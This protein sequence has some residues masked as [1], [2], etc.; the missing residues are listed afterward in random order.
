MT[1]GP[2]P[3]R[4]IGRAKKIAVMLGEVR[5]DRELGRSRYSFMLSRENCTVF[6]RVKRVRTHICDPQEIQRLFR[7][8]ILQLRTIPKTPV[9]SR[10][11]WTLSPWGTWQFFR[12]ENDRLVEVRYDGVPVHEDRQKTVPEKSSPGSCSKTP[13][14]PPPGPAVPPD[15]AAGAGTGEDVIRGYLRRRNAVSAAGGGMPAP[16]P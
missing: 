13:A 3:L 10:E 5:D 2:Q 6:V 15:K 4:A 7:Q 16:D 8:D 1:K 14:T 9:Q 11:I 12:V